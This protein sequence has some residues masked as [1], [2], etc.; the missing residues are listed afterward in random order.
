[1]NYFDIQY[2][3]AFYLKGDIEYKDL[4]LKLLLKSLYFS[5]TLVTSYKRGFHGNFS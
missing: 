3:V 2:I 4:Y 5:T 1:M